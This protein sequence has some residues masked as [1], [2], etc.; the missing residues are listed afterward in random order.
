MT[1]T[2]TSGVSTA[3]TLKT[4]EQDNVDNLQGKIKHEASSVYK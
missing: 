4:G 3:H 2:H 1:Q